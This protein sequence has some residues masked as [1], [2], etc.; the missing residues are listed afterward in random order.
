M[1]SPDLALMALYL[2]VDLTTEVQCQLGP[3]CPRPAIWRLRLEC[4]HALHGCRDCK[5]DVDL[6]TMGSRSQGERPIMSHGQGCRAVSTSWT[7]SLL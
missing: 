3:T 5:Q 1:T 2:G 4:G 6:T 7:W